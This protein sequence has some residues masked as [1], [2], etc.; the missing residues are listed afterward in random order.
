MLDRRFDLTERE[1]PRQWYNI[2]ADLP[3]KPPPP[4]H[5]GTGQPVGP[6]RPGADLPDG[7]DHAGGQPASAG[8]TIPEEV[9][10]HLRALAAHAALPRRPAGEGA[11]HA[12]EDLLQVR[13]RQ[14]GGQPQAEHRRAAGLLQQAGRR[15]ADRHRDRRGPVGLRAGLRLQLFG[16][17]CKVYMVRVSYDQKPYRAVDDADLGRER[18]RRAHRTDTE[19]GPGDPGSRTRTSPGSLG[20]AI[21]EAVEDAATREDTKY[22]LGSVLNHVLPAPDRHRP[23]GEEADGAR[24]ATTR[25]SSSAASAAAATSPAS[26]FPFLADKIAGRRIRIVAVEPASCPTLTR[27]EFRYDFGDTAR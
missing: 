1:I 4:L 3:E 18:R 24:R 12:G 15:Q 25:T 20:I 26:A 21:S 2:M 19:C 27:G 14:P 9:R 13:G 16:L 17:E 10:R 6:E 5:P 23:G 8:S 22:A 11:R 7:A